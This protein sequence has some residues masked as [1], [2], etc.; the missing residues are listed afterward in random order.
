[1]NINELQQRSGMT[2][3]EIAQ[4]LGITQPSVSK[5]RKA[6]PIERC[7]DIERVT[8][9]PRNVLRPDIFEARP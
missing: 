5:W 9:I 3:R 1:M 8:G 4:A 2:Q 7:A 6:V